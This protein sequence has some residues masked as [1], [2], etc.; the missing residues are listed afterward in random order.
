MIFKKKKLPEVPKK[1]EPEVIKTFAIYSFWLAKIVPGVVFDSEFFQK[2]IHWKTSP[3]TN[4]NN[5]RPTSDLLGIYLIHNN[6]V[7]EA[8]NF[9]HTDKIVFRPASE[10][11]PSKIRRM[12]RNWWGGSYI[13]LDISK[14]FISGDFSKRYPYAVDF[15]VN[16]TTKAVSLKIKY[17]KITLHR[18]INNIEPIVELFEESFRIKMFSKSTANL[19]RLQAHSYWSDH[20]LPEAVWVKLNGILKNFIVD[21]FGKDV[22][23]DFNV[24]SLATAFAMAYF[25][26]EPRLF[27]LLRELKSNP[28]PAELTS[29]KTPVT[30]ES[31]R[32]DLN[33]FHQYFSDVPKSI[34]RLYLKD[35]FVLPLYK[36]LKY[37]FGI[38]DINIIRYWIRFMIGVYNRC[39]KHVQINKDD[40]AEILVKN[41]FDPEQGYVFVGT[42]QLTRILQSYRILK[43]EFNLSS[44]KALNT[45]LKGLNANIGTREFWDTIYMFQNNWNRFDKDATVIREFLKRG[46]CTA[47]HDLLSIEISNLGKP[48]IVFENITDKQR[49]RF[50]CAIRVSDRIY[51][52]KLAEDS[53]RLRKIG[54]TLKICVGS[55]G[56]DEKVL[57]GK[58]LIAFVETDAQYVGCIE[59]RQEQIVHQ[60]RTYCNHAFAGELEQV[61]EAW[62]KHSKLQFYGNY[63]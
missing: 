31:D 3:T 44:E 9:S 45:L 61:F 57:K 35:P 11:D 59:I 30:L 29:A 17:I 62:L 7:W 16:Y 22:C 50:E 38:D 20:G 52:F 39:H 19:A 41:T 10:Q 53:N 63:F 8:R 33:I 49:K 42:T 46:V 55:A 27:F 6:I 48:N 54:D 56:Y 4:I 1:Q 37:D 32:S 43:K 2:G 40:T 23:P 60:A 15:I 13:V 24:V 36:L 47:T 34:K 21:E 26:T 18:S 25:P 5:L 14:R 12:L 28:D 51:Y 58:C